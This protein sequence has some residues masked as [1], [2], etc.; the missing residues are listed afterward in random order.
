MNIHRIFMIAINLSLVACLVPAQAIASEAPEAAALKS[1]EWRSIGP[2]NT[3]GR[4]TDIAGIPGD[5]TTFFVAGADGG[6]WKT[7]NSGTTFEPLFED[8]PVYSVGAVTLAPSDHHII[9]LG[10]GEGD[11]RNSVSYG[12][13]VYRSTDGG[14]HWKHL[15]LDKTERIKRIAVDPQNPDIALVCAVGREWGPNEERGV[16]KTTDG[17]QNWEKVLYIDEDTGCSEIA[18][19]PSNP[20]YVYAGMW[21]FRRQPWR[22][23]GGGGETAL[24]KS[25]DGGATWTKKTAGLPKGPMARIGLAIARS[26]PN[27][28][29]LITE[30]KDEGVLFRSEDWGESWVKVHDNPNINFRPF[31]YS[32]IR[33][34]PNDPDVVYSLSGP[35]NKST[36][37]GKTFKTI[38]QSVHGDHQALW[39]DPENSNRILN[40]NDGGYAVSYDGGK[41]W[42]ILNNVVLSQFYQIFF[43]DRDPYYVCGGLQ[44]NGNWCGPSRTGHRAGIL[45]DDWYTVSFGD[46]FYTVPIPGEPHLVYSNIQGGPIYI[47]DTRSGSMRL[48]SPYPRKSGSAGDAIVDH[49]Y[50]FNWDAPIHISPHDPKTVYYGGNVLFK[51]TNYGHSWE[52]ISP[53]LT[54]DDAEKQQSS[55]GPVYVDNTAA[56]FHCTILT[57]A[58]SPVEAGVIWVGTD[59]GNIQVTRD[60]GANWNNVT[61]NV[62]E[63][64][65]FTWVA[66]FEAS[67]F[68]SG[69]A[70]VAVDNHRLDDFKPHVFKT[71]DYGETWTSLAGG[72][73]QDDYVKVVRED[74]KNP[75]LLYVGMERGLFASWD[76]GKTWVSIRNNL[77]P[78][79]VRDIK[80]HPRENDLIIGTH[81]RGAWI[82]D[83]IAPLQ[84]LAEA[85]KADSYLFDV[86][87]ATRWQ[88]WMRHASLGEGTFVAP[89]PPA[90]AFINYYL[91]EAPEGP[92]EITITDSAGQPVIDLTEKQPKAGVNRTVWNLRHAGPTPI[93]VLPPEAEG[94]MAMVE[95]IFG[96][97]GPPAVPGDYTVSLKIGEN[98]HST[99]V[100][101]KGDPRL[102]L[103]QADY[104]AQFKAAK[105][106]RELTSKVN[107][108]IDTTL[109]LRM[110]LA[111]LERQM[112]MAGA[113]GAEQMK[114]VA[115]A[116]KKASEEVKAIDNRLRQPV[117]GMM[118]RQY[119]R[120]MEELFMSTIFLVA[121]SSPPTEGQLVVIEELKQ[122]AEI[123]LADVDKLVSTTIKDLNQMLGAFPKIMVKPPTE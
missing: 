60:G 46:G 31:Y 12:N 37:G 94:M 73:P 61:G 101:V 16:F 80:I 35:L 99:K 1:L 41:A 36:D 10:T 15:G 114:P 25:T 34:D 59:D 112:K 9:W 67:N 65:A 102:E 76:G 117:M 108:A 70:Y 106:L 19:D 30:A 81:G 45:K 92:L 89:N 100:T 20:R 28:V 22:F 44:D 96:S 27:I 105:D 24:Y 55:G 78:V 63:L 64:P 115:E 18:M 47:T 120:M 52:E 68:E 87:P 113:A 39:I 54:T 104:E 57:I 110:Q 119:P 48:I 71:T 51:S 4:V 93:S 82:L 97:M 74:P 58:E 14:K 77:P 116:V 49:K 88:L 7:T 91:Q 111:G 43:D 5:P 11:P 83:D 2:A 42:T 72:L 121:S 69:T 109:G 98:E 8:Q 50:R 107:G 123:I 118:Y 103:S 53:D 38:A 3:S 86:R 56:E 79:S 13:G 85:M 122:D 62:K 17:G 23:D 75:N 95:R 40:G 90:G 84:K 66:K 29:Y 21:T 6:L 26:Q 33:V 32:D